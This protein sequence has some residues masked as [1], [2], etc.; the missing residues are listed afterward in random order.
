MGPTWL[1][2][3]DLEHTHTHTHHDARVNPYDLYS[4]D[5]CQ[6]MPHSLNAHPCIHATNPLDSPQT[7]HHTHAQQTNTQKPPFAYNSHL[8]NQ[9]T[10]ST[11]TL[12]T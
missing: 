2:H 3:Y 9:D 12:T 7:S 8:P 11:D 6:T 1:I 5:L 10:T 4:L